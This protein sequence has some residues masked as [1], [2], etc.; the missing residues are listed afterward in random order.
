MKKRQ[1]NTKK[2]IVLLLALF[3]VMFVTSITAI[4]YISNRNIIFSTKESNE[5][6]QFYYPNYSNINYRISLIKQL[7]EL[8]REYPIF[9]V[10]SQNKYNFTKIEKPEIVVK[11]QNLSSYNEEPNR[12]NVS[13]SVI[14]KITTGEMMVEIITNKATYSKTISTNITRQS[15]ED[16]LTAKI[17]E[18]SG[19]LQD[20]LF[21]E[22]KRMYEA[23]NVIIELKDVRHKNIDPQKSGPGENIKNIEVKLNNSIEYHVLVKELIVDKNKKL[24]INRKLKI[25]AEYEIHALCNVGGGFYH[26]VSNIKEEPIFDNSTPPKQTGTEYTFDCI[27]YIGYGSSNFRVFKKLKTRIVRIDVKEEI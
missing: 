4:V 12:D 22:L 16:E 6:Y 19:S 15:I 11:F 5:N 9:N 24:P 18:S 27:V 1:V 8:D 17:K 23:N 20:D 26:E 3:I 21:E 10:E 25:I 7:K 2:G 14:L 13:P